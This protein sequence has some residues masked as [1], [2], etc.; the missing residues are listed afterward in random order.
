[1]QDTLIL[2]IAEDYK[3]FKEAMFPLF[4]ELR[5][6]QFAKDT[7]QSILEYIHNAKDGADML[8]EFIDELE[9]TMTEEG[10]DEQEIA[11]VKEATLELG[12][13]MLKHLLDI[14]AYDMEGH[15]GFKLKEILGYDIALQP[16]SPE[17]L[18]DDE[19]DISEVEDPSTIVA[20]RDELDR[21]VLYSEHGDN[22]GDDDFNP[23]ERLADD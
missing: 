5:Y 14:G 8:Q 16:L 13:A 21:E 1:M 18:A 19:I 2:D 15:L 23:Y 7:I 12:Q 4:G 20:L 11:L 22:E 3:R 10:M 9:E 6:R 17:D